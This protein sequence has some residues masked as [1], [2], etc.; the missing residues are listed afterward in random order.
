M[1][2]LQPRG[3]VPVNVAHIVGRAVFT[4]VGQVQPGAAQQRAV[5]ALAQAVELADDG[6][7]Q[8]AQQLL[9]RTGK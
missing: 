2:H 1:R 9:G 4:Q 5:V 3:D 8:A 6:P 7:L